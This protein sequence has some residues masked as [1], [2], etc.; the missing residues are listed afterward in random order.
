MKGGFH[1]NTSKNYEVVPPEYLVKI[2]ANNSW[3]YAFVFLLEVSI[4]D[5]KRKLEPFI[6]FLEIPSRLFSM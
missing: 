5:V 4:K 6:I 1:V 2:P 3:K